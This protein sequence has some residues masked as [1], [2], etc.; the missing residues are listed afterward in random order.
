M[1]EKA[2]NL[3]IE[4]RPPSYYAKALP[5]ELSQTTLPDS[6]YYK[7]PLRFYSLPTSTTSQ[8]RNKL[9]ESSMVFTINLIGFRPRT[10][11]IRLGIYLNIILAFNQIFVLNRYFRQIAI[12]DLNKV[13]ILCNST[14]YTSAK[15]TSLN[16]GGVIIVYFL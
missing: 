2:F 11:P 8:V 6:I 10:Y 7:K 4:T 16:Y 9:W 5:T 3:A 12:T 13:Q 1:N 14:K 15:R